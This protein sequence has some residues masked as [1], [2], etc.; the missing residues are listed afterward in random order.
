MNNEIECLCCAEANE[1][2]DDLFEGKFYNPVMYLNPYYSC[3]FSLSF[4]LLGWTKNNLSL[5][6]YYFSVYTF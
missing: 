2:P 6:S 3:Q 5:F 1:I 4:L